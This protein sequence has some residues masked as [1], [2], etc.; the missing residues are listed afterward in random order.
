MGFIPLN[1]LGATPAGQ[2]ETYPPGLYNLLVK[3]VK[4]ETSKSGEPKLVVVFTIVDGPDG[5]PANRDKTLTRSYTLQPQH[6]GFFLRLVYAVGYTEADLQATGG[7]CSEEMLVGRP[8]RAR[9]KIK[10]YQDRET[11][12]IEEL[13]D[14]KMIHAPRTQQPAQQQQMPTAMAPQQYPPQQQYAPPAGQAQM[15]A[16]PA[17][18][19]QYAPPPQQYAP[20][21]AGFTPPQAPTASWPG[22]AP[23]YPGGNGNGTGVAAAPPPPPQPMAHK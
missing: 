7:M 2:F 12:E 18:Q 23:G 10:M 1:L 5:N 8:I 22:G 20:P 17:Q 9:M 16:P 3:E 19:P 4:Q 11:N 14:E 15:Y 6:R 13:F 21:P